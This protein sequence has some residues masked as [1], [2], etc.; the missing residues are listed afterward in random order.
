MRTCKACGCYI[1]DLWSECPACGRVL[2]DGG[3]TGGGKGGST[4]FEIV[5]VRYGSG[6]EGVMHFPVPTPKTVLRRQDGEVEDLELLDE[7]DAEIMTRAIAY[8]GLG[9]NAASQESSCFT[10][11]PGVWSRDPNVKPYPIELESYWPRSEIK[12]HQGTNK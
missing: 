10:S 1:P 8:R 4:T 5:D 2:H 6:N 7:P 3:N 11:T 9:G 12:L